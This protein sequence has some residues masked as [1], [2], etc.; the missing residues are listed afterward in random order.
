MTRF[1]TAI[2]SLSR[3]CAVLGSICLA[4]AAVVIVWMVTYRTLGNSTSWELELSIFLMV[5]SLFLASPYTLLTRGHVGVDL[6]A[7]YMSER[8][9]RR[10]NLVADGLGLVVCVFLAFVCFEFALEAYIKGDRTESV[11]AP[12][13]WPLY[14]AMPIGFGLTALQYIALISEYFSEKKVVA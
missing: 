2:A 8:N 4:M 1:C 14:A 5:V 13:K 11:W 12:P 6:L 9:A 3:F 10:L 7:H